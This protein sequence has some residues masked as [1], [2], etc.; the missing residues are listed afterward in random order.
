MLKNNL[1]EEA[2]A[3]FTETIIIAKE[4]IAKSSYV[5]PYHNL[6][7]SYFVL[8]NRK[9]C[10]TIINKSFEVSKN[11]AIIEETIFDFN[12]MKDEKGVPQDLLKECLILFN[13]AIVDTKQLV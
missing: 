6:A 13:K 2:K 5:Y 3:Y 9:D 11:P 4:E 7:F 12:L 8:N 10:I 1:L